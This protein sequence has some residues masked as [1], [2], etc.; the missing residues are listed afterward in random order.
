[1]LPTIATGN[2]AS[3][4]PSGY[5]VANSCKFNDGDSAYMHLTTGSSGNRRTFTFSCWYKRCTISNATQ[6][7][8]DKQKFE[9]LNINQTIG[10]TSKTGRK[11]NIDMKI[12]ST[13][14]RMT[15]FA[16]VDH[17]N[18]TSISSY[19]RSEVAFIKIYGGQYF[20]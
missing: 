6:S 11:S 14:T 3:A 1:M 9:L 19:T 15:E 12:D 2:V 18:Y 17:R 4:L 7:L 10:S 8:L 16:K 13:K 20:G 5:D